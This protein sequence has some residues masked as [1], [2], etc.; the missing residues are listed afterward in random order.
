MYDVVWLYV[1]V[2]NEILEM[3]I[4]IRNGLEVVKRIYNRFYEG[5]LL[6]FVSFFVYN[7]KFIDVEV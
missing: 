2:V 3:G 6:M 4:S 7:M 1:L 5:I